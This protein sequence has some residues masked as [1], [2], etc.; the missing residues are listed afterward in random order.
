MTLRTYVNEQFGYTYRTINPVVGLCWLASACQLYTCNL[1][2][3]KE[4]WKDYKQNTSSSGQLWLGMLRFAAYS[5]YYTQAFLSANIEHCL[6]LCDFEV[7]STLKA[8]CQ[9]IMT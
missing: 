2:L 8:L 6:G 4:V 9:Y 1:F 7:P 5:T 3:Q